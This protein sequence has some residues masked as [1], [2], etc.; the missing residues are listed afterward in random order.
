AAVPIT[1]SYD[2]L[3]R[4]TRTDYPDSTFETTTYL[5]WTTTFADRNGHARS[6]LKDA[7]GRV[8]QITEPGGAL[9]R[10][11]YDTTGRL[12]AVTDAAGHLT[13]IVYDT[14][15]RKIRMTEPNMGTWTYS[16]DPNGN[17][18]IQT[19]ARYQ[20]LSF[21]YDALNRLV[22]KT[23]PGPG[24]YP[25]TRSEKAG[26]EGY[27]ALYRGGICVGACT[28]GDVWTKAGLGPSLGYMKDSQGTGTQP[29]YES[30]CYS[31][32]AGTC[33][34]WGLSLD[35]NGA[36]VG[37][38]AQTD[39]N[40]G[41]AL[42]QSGGLLYQG[43]GGTPSAYL[44]NPPP[45]ATRT[46]HFYATDGTVPLGY[47]DQGLLGYLAE[48]GGSGTV[49]LTRYE[50]AAGAHFYS[51]T[52]TDVPEGEGYTAEATLG[53]LQT[54][55]G[56]GLSPLARHHNPTTGDYLLSTSTTPPGGYTYQGTLGYLHTP[57]TLPGGT[58]TFTY[59]ADGVNGKGRRTGM[60]DFAGGE[61]YVYDALGRLS[62]TTRIID[63]V[64]YTTATT[65]TPFGAPLTL[66]Y[67]DAETLTSH[68]T[69]GQLTALT[70]STGGTY[71]SG[72]AYNAAGQLTELTYGNGAV[73]KRTYE[74]T[75]LRLASIRTNE[76]ALQNLHYTYDNVGNV[77][78]IEDYQ[79]PTHA[80]D[81]NFTYDELNR[82]TTASGPYGTHNF[83]YSSIGNILTKEGVTYTYGA[84][85]QTCNRVMPHAVTATSDGQRYSYDCN[86]NLLADS[87]RTL[88]WDADNRPSFITRGEATTSF[89]YSGD[90]VRVKKT[91]IN[92]TIR[93]V[94]GF[95]DHVTDSSTTKHI[96]VGSLHVATRVVGG[97]HPGTYYPHG[98]HLGS[99]NVLTSTSGA[100]VQRLTY[101][102]YGETA[103]DVHTLGFL[104]LRFTGQEEDPETGLY[105]Y[106][107]RYYNP[108][109]GRFISPDSMV[110]QPENP[111]DLNRYSYARNNPIKLVDPTGHHS[112][113]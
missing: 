94:G 38:L 1:Y 72:I 59:D 50:N 8:T 64:A 18:L 113:D 101:L 54:T 23:Y 51:V 71:A 87:E 88:T 74:E 107:A 16:Y 48:A 66:R 41:V 12:T 27:T 92:A 22:T 39:P 109:L 82:L 42:T 86:G 93:Y 37:Y 79:D 91:G 9:T 57:G 32:S 2:A 83:S 30:T 31:D 3:G 89:L 70:S 13:S 28:G 26:F 96:R 60:T 17:L 6:S 76:G 36:P 65:Y 55:G 46:D 63:G 78:K 90:G 47:T 75:T 19:D 52:G 53:Y 99:L 73:T 4:L 58:V 111:Q 7:Y 106:G 14:L 56:S 43:L 45:A 102:P 62:Q 34:G 108:A 69:T 35:A 85:M 11:G 5:H 68:Y 67:P 20:T 25:L 21:Q 95:E 40:P 10:Y 33:T 104:K 105:Y 110:P 112:G 15:G 103:S 81:Q 84:T 29:V 77:T 80:H 61:S 44:W 24:F 49:T 100:E 97:D 98:D